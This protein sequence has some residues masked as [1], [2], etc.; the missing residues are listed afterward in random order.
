MTKLQ[1]RSRLVGAAA[2]PPVACAVLDK[3]Q[4]TRAQLLHLANHWS[5]VARASSTT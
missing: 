1:R 4:P 3:A 5:D 2:A